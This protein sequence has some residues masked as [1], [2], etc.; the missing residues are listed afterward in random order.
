[1]IENITSPQLHWRAVKIQPIKSTNIWSCNIYVKVSCCMQYNDIIIRIYNTNTF[2]L[3][4][5]LNKNSL[6][7]DVYKFETVLICKTSDG[8]ISDYTN[9]LW[10][11][12]TRHCILY[13]IISLMK[14]N[15]LLKLY[16]C[17]E[18]NVVIRPCSHV[19]KLRLLLISYR[20]NLKIVLEYTELRYKWVNLQLSVNISICCPATHKITVWI[21]MLFVACEESF[22]SKSI[23]TH[24]HGKMQNGGNCVHSLYCSPNIPYFEE[25]TAFCVNSVRKLF[26]DSQSPSVAG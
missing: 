2:S 26:P 11:L 4:Q 12:K 7:H 24:N 25:W 13:Q 16:L 9:I 23:S 18:E 14:Y 8:I 17:C 10:K 21:S 15:I 19:T 22:I 5:K 3:L 20:Y 6:L 1:M